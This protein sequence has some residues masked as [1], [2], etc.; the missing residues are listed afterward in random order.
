MGSKVKKGKMQVYSLISSISSNFY[1]FTAYSLDLFIRV[2]SQPHGEHTV[3]QPFRR[4]E[5]NIEKI[6]KYIEG[7]NMIFLGKSCTK[8]DSNPHDR[9]L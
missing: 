4:I 9:Q 5:H 2:P 1:I 6:S 7:R 3:M 8:R